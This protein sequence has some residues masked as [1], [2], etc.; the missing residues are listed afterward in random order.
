MRCSN[1]GADFEGNFCPNCGQ[2]AYSNA[3]S[4][5][6][7]KDPKAEAQSAEQ[8][9]ILKE[10]FRV[11]Q[12]QLNLQ[13]ANEHTNMV[14]PRCHSN[15]VVVQ[16]VAEQKGRGCFMTL[17]WIVLAICTFGIIL[18]LIPLLKR[19]GTRTHTYAVC[20]SCGYKWKV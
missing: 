5:E 13:R 1:C 12:E 18:L 3:R 7:V 9:N 4:P 10:Q 11:Q 14:C 2:A 19:N 8:L 15:N 17:L 20:Q 6:M 16:A